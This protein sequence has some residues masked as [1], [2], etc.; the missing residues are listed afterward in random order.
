MTE[1]TLQHFLG[2]NSMPHGEP[3]LYMVAVA[4]ELHR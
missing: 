1:L 3:A 4:V 2:I